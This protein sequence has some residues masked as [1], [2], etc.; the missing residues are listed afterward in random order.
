VT[1]KN[2]ISDRVF[3]VFVA[4]GT[5]RIT[6]HPIADRLTQRDAKRRAVLFHKLQQ[7]RRGLAGHPAEQ[8][9]LRRI[10]NMGRNIL[11]GPLQRNVD[12]ALARQFLFGESSNAE[13]RAEFYNL[14]KQVNLANPTI[15]AVFN[16]E[17]CIEYRPP[18]TSLL[19]LG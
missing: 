7:T 3:I 10:G 6:L 15:K 18:A 11:R 5:T 19:R 13:F 2:E 8:N 4:G 17:I 9:E 12:I 1:G 16:K 14:F